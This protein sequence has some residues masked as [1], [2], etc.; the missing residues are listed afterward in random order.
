MTAQLNERALHVMKLLVERYL[1]DGTP[2]SSKCLVGDAGI[3][4]SPATVR[5]VMMNLEKIGLL[6]SPHTS[7]GRIPTAQGLRIFVDELLTVSPLEQTVTEHIESRLSTGLTPIQ[8]CQQ[9]SSILADMTAM[10]GLVTVPKKNQTKIEKIEFIRLTER[11]LILILVMHNGEIQNRIIELPNPIDNA[12]LLQA[13]RLLALAMA[14][15]TLDQG[16]ARVHKLATESNVKVAQL[17]TA[18][19]QLAS[20]TDQEEVVLHGRHSLLDASISNELEKIRALYEAVSQKNTLLELMH[21]C[22]QAQGV[23]LFIGEE[24]GLSSFDSCSVISAPYQANGQIVG[25]LAVIG[26]TRMDY[27][28][29]IPIVDITAQILSSALNQKS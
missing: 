5:N 17:S 28:K 2:V 23:K 22:Q 24:S 18:A 26:P 13:G 15:Q 1:S 10:T 6:A 27:K 20:Q 4:A 9:A 14:G 21:K 25:R 19:L 16:F 8:L 12:T 7:A 3:S 11:R 29:V